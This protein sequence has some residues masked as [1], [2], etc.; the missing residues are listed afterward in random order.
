MVF[1]ILKLQE[2]VLIEK[3]AAYIKVNVKQTP[4]PQ[5]A[6][7]GVLLTENSGKAKLNLSNQVTAPL[8]PCPLIRLLMRT[9]KFLGFFWFVFGWVHCQLCVGE[10]FAFNF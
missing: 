8:Y 9:M 5:G 1:S 7:E 3:L 4:N 2:R 6:N 10:R